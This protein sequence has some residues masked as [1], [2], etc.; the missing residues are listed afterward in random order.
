MSEAIHVI[1]RAT[2]VKGKE[3]E[4]S[5][6]LRGMLSPTHAEPGD[7]IYDLYESDTP[8]RFYFYEVWPSRSALNIHA[9]TNHFKQLQSDLKGLIAEPLEINILKQLGPA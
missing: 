9:A 2:A 6:V 8:G 3:A 4:L 1:A 7:K 5:K